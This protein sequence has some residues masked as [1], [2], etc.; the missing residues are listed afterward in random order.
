MHYVAHGTLDVPEFANAAY[1]AAKSYLTH[2]PVERRLFHRLEDAPARHYR[3]AIN[4]R[5]DD[6]F[7]PN[8]DTIA[9]DPYSALRTTNGSRQS[10]AL[11]LGHEVDH[12]VESPR[13]EARLTA[14]A[15]ANYDNR[16][17]R[18]VILGSETHAA[19]T[20]HE[21]TR[22]DHT[23]SAYRVASPTAR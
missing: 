16:E 1:E 20:L 19:H 13:A 14:R 22:H 12:A 5:N 18:R 23:G 17:E 8:T 10:P 15:D 2:D 3:L 21:G 7:D 9:W 6:H 11:G 4:H